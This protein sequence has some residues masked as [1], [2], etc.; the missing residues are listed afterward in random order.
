MT[1][2]NM[3][4]RCLPRTPPRWTCKFSPLF[5]A[6]D[7]RLEFDILPFSPGGHFEFF[8]VTIRSAGAILRAT[9]RLSA[10][11]GMELNLPHIN[12]PD[13]TIF[14][15]SIPKFGAGIVAD[16]FVNFAE[17]NTNITVAPDGDFCELPVVEAY[18]LAIGAAVGATLKLN[19]HTWGPAASSSTALFYTTLAS[20]CA[21]K[22]NP[23]KSSSVAVPTK[24]GIQAR[25]LTVTTI[26]T[27][28][29]YTGVA[30]RSSG[31]VNC[32]ASLQTT[33]QETSTLKLTTLV[34]SGAVPTF[35]ASTSNYV[36][37][38]IPF[39][40]NVH[41]LAA[42]SGTPTPYV[43]SPLATGHTIVDGRTGKVKNKLIIGLS[44]GIGVPVLIGL[45]AICV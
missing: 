7:C 9:L 13:I 5:Y 1:E 19:S 39:G 26:S 27:V 8:P 17:F 3:I 10:K 2:S 38:T 24:G 23:V 14:N 11:A 16:T 36:T 31:L 42:L 35:P 20:A 4:L 33:T 12:T 25:S 28:R 6:H 45:S 15:N 18:S 41:K 30:C 44:V 43:P 37:A 34:T 29:V 32:P 22:G 40:T 21:V